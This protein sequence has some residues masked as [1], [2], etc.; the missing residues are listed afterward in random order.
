MRERS[1]TLMGL[2]KS[3]SMGG[4]RVGFALAPAEV[5]ERMITVQQHL[6]TCVSSLAQAGART[7]WKR[8]S[9]LSRKWYWT[10]ERLRWPASFPI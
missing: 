7:A 2:T 8:R 3:F 6:V 4:W 5:I 1:V 10:A 9:S